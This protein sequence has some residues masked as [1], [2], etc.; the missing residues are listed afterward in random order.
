MIKNLQRAVG[1][2]QDGIAGPA[3]YTALFRKCGASVDRA[4]ELGLAAN[5]RFAEYSLLDNPLRLS[6]FF[7]TGYEYRLNGGEPIVLA[8]DKVITGLEPD[9]TYEVQVRS[10][11]SAGSISQMQWFG[12]RQRQLDSVLNNDGLDERRY[13][14]AMTVFGT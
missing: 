10:V 3:T 13:R 5:V 9:T 6:H 8:N 12:L 11:N 4:E 2:T 14:A 7:A 1:T